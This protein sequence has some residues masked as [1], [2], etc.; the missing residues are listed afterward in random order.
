MEVNTGIT[1]C[2]DCSRSLTADRDKLKRVMFN[3]PR[4]RDCYKANITNYCQYWSKIGIPC[5]Y[6]AP[7]GECYCSYHLELPIHLRS[8]YRPEAEGQRGLPNGRAEHRAGQHNNGKRKSARSRKSMPEIPDPCTDD[9][10]PA[11]QLNYYTV[12][13]VG[14]NC[15]M[16]EIR[17]AYITKA[18]TLHPDKN[19]GRGDTTILFQNLQAAYDALMTLKLHSCS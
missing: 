18:R 3:I 19:I 2:I 11:I 4:C 16:E 13:G 5:K 15:T 17:R 14:R 10:L 6:K 12:V 1:H 7:F 9:M 8:K